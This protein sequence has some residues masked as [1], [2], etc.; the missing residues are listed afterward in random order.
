MVKLASTTTWV[1]RWEVQ[2]LST[3]SS[4]VVAQKSDGSW[5]CSCPRW[6]FS[7]ANGD[8]HRPDCKHIRA[9]RDNEPIA[10]DFQLSQ[11]ERFAEVQKERRRRVRDTQPIQPTF[12]LQTRR[13]IQL[14]D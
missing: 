8:G 13:T 11:M 10:T 4:Y 9:V 3:D 14:V 12:L 1:N 7:K 6:R 2:S 5:G